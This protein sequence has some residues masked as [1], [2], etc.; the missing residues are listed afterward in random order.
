[1]PGAVF[2]RGEGRTLRT[3]EPEDHEF[4]HRY[5]NKPSIRY[6]ALRT[7][8]FS[9]DDVGTFVDP[10][11]GVHFLTCLDG[12]P[13]GIVTLVDVFPEAGNGKLGY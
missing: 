13:V 8:P 10:E 1:M 12:T 9:K 3:I 7:T 4:I 11:R 6:G 5:G 2:L